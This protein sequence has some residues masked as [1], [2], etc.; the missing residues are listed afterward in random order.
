MTVSGVRRVLV[1]VPMLMLL[2]LTATACQQT[3]STTTQEGSAAPATT[4]SY[5]PDTVFY[6]GV[7]SVRFGQ[8]LDELTDSPGVEEGP[9]GCGTHIVGLEAVNPVFTD[10]DPGAKLVLIWANPPLRTPEGVGVGSDVGTAKA[11]YPKAT[12]LTAPSESLRF[13]GLLST[14]G[15]FGYLLL[16]DGKK[17]QKLIVGYTTYLRQLF[18]RGFGAC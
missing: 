8:T 15:D 7:R 14:E 10:D 16:H 9:G 5:G 4:A 2:G 6:Q 18:E 11:A 12:A 17:V 13:D 3:A 1:C